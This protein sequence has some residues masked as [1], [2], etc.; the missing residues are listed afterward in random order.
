MLHAAISS[1]AGLAVAAC[2]RPAGCAAG[3][4]AGAEASW[5]LLLHLLLLRQICTAHARCM[6]ACGLMLLLRR[7]ACGGVYYSRAGAGTAPGL[8][9][10]CPGRSDLCR[11]P[12]HSGSAAC[13]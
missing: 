6:Q 10:C 8:L 3:M 13:W 11:G 5:L 2:L 4:L 7:A 12:D 9:P 1:S